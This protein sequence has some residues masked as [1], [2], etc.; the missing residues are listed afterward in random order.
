MARE[1][2]AECSGARGTPCQKQGRLV[3]QLDTRSISAC[4]RGACIPSEVPDL[5]SGGHSICIL[6]VQVLSGGFAV[7]GHSV[8]L[9]RVGFGRSR[10]KLQCFRSHRSAAAAAGMQ[11]RKRV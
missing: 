1:E 2:T 3:L 7:Q 10:T 4:V 5:V 8:G 6:W 9:F 11:Y